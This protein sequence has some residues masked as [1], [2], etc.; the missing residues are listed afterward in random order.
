M[1]DDARARPKSCPYPLKIGEWGG[2]PANE[3]EIEEVA[4]ERR[5][6]EAYLLFVGVAAVVMPGYHLPRRRSRS[7]PY[8]SPS[9]VPS[10]LSILCRYYPA[11]GAHRSL[12]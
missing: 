9:T 7:D 5:A 12:E 10:W 8:I 2:L 1:T 11:C 3:G 4:G 6:L